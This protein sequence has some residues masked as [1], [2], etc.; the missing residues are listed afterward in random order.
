MPEQA[1]GEARRARGEVGLRGDIHPRRAEPAD[2]VP[3]RVEDGG[4]VGRPGA[5]HLN[6]AGVGRGDAVAHPGVQVHDGAVE[7]VPEREV[8]AVTGVRAVVVAVRESGPCQVSRKRHEPGRV[9]GTVAGA[10]HLVEA[11]TVARRVAIRALFL[12][13]AEVVEVGLG[14]DVD[15]GLVPG[16]DDVTGVGLRDGRRARV[17]GDRQHVS[18]EE[19]AVVDRPAVGQRGPRAD[20]VDVAGEVT[21]GLGV[22]GGVEP[23]HV[24]A[25]ERVVAAAVLQRGAGLAEDVPGE[26]ALGGPVRCRVE[27][28]AGAALRWRHRVGPRERRVP[29]RV[30]G[31]ERGDRHG[32]R[33]HP[34]VGVPVPHELVV[35]RVPH[36]LQVPAVGHVVQLD[37]HAATEPA[38]RDGA[39]HHEPVH[40]GAGRPDDYLAGRA[41]VVDVGGPA[42]EELLLLVAISR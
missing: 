25:A 16:L 1:A 18:A 23:L 41:V 33:R 14:L 38:G 20:G 3:V 36:L 13:A 15:H 24:E 17:E 42:V 9:L 7:D 5:G 27:I 30:E 6:S 39:E 10:G 34:D 32:R 29:G 4:P 12:E 40:V 26:A 22:A 11:V 8:V 2:C 35:V 21:G 31:L 19:V 37:E 28:G